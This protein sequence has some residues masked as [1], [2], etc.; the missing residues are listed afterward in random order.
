M[1]SVKA[2]YDGNKIHFLENVNF[3]E[4]R[5]IIITFL[6]KS[7]FDLN[8]L[9]LTQE[10]EIEV[11]DISSNEIHY[12]L[13]EGKAFDFLNNKEEDIYSDKDLKIKY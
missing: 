10:N 12:I 7:N 11:N 2:I 5:E 13:Q 4:P 6:N 1:L 8:K 3:K 9:D